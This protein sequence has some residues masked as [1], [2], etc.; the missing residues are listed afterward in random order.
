V[1]GVP[2]MLDTAH[3]WSLR[4]SVY[5]MDRIKFDEQ[6]SRYLNDKTICNCNRD[7]ICS[8]TNNGDKSIQ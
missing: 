8:C 7:S 4:E 1:D 2:Y 6:S 5:V 3:I